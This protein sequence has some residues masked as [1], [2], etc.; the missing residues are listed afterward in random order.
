MTYEHARISFALVTD[1]NWTDGTHA[2]RY[3]T[4]LEWQQLMEYK[5]GFVARLIPLDSGHDYPLAY[6]DLPRD[7]AKTRSSTCRTHT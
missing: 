1:Q 4:A 6:D 5:H 3:E 7:G 2:H